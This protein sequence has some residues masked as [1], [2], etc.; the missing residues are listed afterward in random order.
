MASGSDEEERRD[1]DLGKDSVEEKSVKE[2]GR[3]V[4]DC[5]EESYLSGFEYEAPN[6]DGYPSDLDD[7]YP[8]GG[9]G[10]RVIEQH[11]GERKLAKKKK[12]KTKKK[13]ASEEEKSQDD[14]KEEDDETVSEGD[15]RQGTGNRKRAVDNLKTDDIQKKR[16]GPS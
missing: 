12:K 15:D 4:L 3:D 5:D 7:C 9:R 13:E 2:D 11:K 14:Y 8:K 6:L 16:R 10:R 1:S